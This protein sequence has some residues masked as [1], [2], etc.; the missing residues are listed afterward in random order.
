MYFSIT[1]HPFWA[2]YIFVHGI[3]LR[4]LPTLFIVP[5]NVYMFIK[6]K[7]IAHKSKSASIQINATLLLIV[8][9]HMILTIPFN[10]MTIIMSAPINNHVNDVEFDDTFFGPELVNGKAVIETESI[11]MNPFNTTLPDHYEKQNNGKLFEMIDSYLPTA[12]FRPKCAEFRRW[13]QG[14]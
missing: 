10:I 12:P 5:M 13:K 8:L 11:T 4:I 14:F 6:I 7:G 2:A 1:R 3:I 9:T